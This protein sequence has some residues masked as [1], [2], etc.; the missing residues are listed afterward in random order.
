MR[1]GATVQDFK[2]AVLTHDELVHAWNVTVAPTVLFFGRG[3][4]EVAP[5]LK[6]IGS[7]DYYGAFLDDRLEQARA[8]IKAH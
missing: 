7:A 4:A 5:R 8:A 1:S 3:G 2:G 6:G